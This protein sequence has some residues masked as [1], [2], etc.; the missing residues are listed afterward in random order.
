[1]QV[2]WFSWRGEWLQSPC[3]C[4]TMVIVGQEEA[5]IFKMGETFHT[6]S[7]VHFS[8][9]ILPPVVSPNKLKSLDNP[10]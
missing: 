5:G 6:Y 4:G 1:M 9:L 2:L 10:G 3:Q 8:S 7:H